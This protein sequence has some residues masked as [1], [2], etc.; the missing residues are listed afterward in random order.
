V[1]PLFKLAGADAE[2]AWNRFVYR[3]RFPGKS[4]FATM[5]PDILKALVALNE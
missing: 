3:A 1:L 4:T 5:R 2:P